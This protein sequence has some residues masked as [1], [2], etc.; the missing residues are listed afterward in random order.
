MQRGK[1][2]RCYINRYGLTF[3]K[4]KQ[5]S[6]RKHRQE[7]IVNINRL[8]SLIDLKRYHMYI[9]ECECFISNFS[10]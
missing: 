7:S 4:K 8:K 10:S 2:S 6:S 3:T 1:N 9:L 5:A